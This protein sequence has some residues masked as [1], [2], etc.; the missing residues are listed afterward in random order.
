MDLL[1]DLWLPS[2]LRPAVKRTAVVF[3]HNPSTG[4][5]L[6]GLP[7]QFPCPHKGYVKVVCQNAAEV[8]RWDKKL[9]DQERHAAEMSDENR[10]SIE[11]PM[12][13][14]ARAEL[15]TK[16]TNS[17]NAINREFCRQA[18]AKIDEYEESLK[19]EKTE[20]FQHI[21]GYEDGK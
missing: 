16:M 17:R 4:H 6:V 1:A 21:V 15:Y 3:Y 14:Q 10:E 2:N 13:K 11:G 7:E 9:R 20:S 12:R 8:D 5:I 19:N 18:I